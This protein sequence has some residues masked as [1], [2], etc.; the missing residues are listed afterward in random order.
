[1][2]KRR[3]KRGCFLAGNEG[4]LRYKRG[5]RWDEHSIRGLEPAPTSLDGIETE[6]GC[7]AMKWDLTRFGGLASVGGA[8]SW[9]TPGSM[10]RAKKFNEEN[11]R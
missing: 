2:G 6:G 3:V 11:L 7:D 10:N 1:M 8:R 5:S 4:E 9:F